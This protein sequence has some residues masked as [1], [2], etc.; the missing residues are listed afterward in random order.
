MRKFYKRA[1]VI[2]LII[3]FIAIP[4]IGKI[5]IDREIKLNVGINEDNELKGD[6]TFVS[7]RTDKREEIQS[8]INE[9]EELYPNVKVNLELIGDAETILQR[10][11]SVGELP[12][13][14][15]VPS[16]IYKNEYSN[17]FLPIDDL[18]FNDNNIYNY[19]MGTGNDSKLYC[20][21][22]SVNWQGV[23][24]NKD[25]FED[26]NIEKL[27]ST[28]EE[29]F[30]ICEKLNDYGVTPIAINYRQ[31]WTM[32][33]CA[34]VI[35]HLFDNNLCKNAAAGNKT[36]LDSESG[37]YKSLNLVREI[38]NR[39]YCEEDLLNYDWQQ[40]K[41]DMST[42]KI[43]MTI[44][45]SDFMYQLED[46]GMDPNSIG[47]F[48][49]PESI[50]VKIYGDY[51][52][53]VSKKTENPQVAKEFLK[54]I[55]EDNRYSNAVNIMSPLKGEDTYSNDFIE[56]NEYDIPIEIYSDYVRNQSVED[57]K[58]EETYLQ[59]KKKNGLDSSFVQKYIIEDNIEDLIKDTN[60][61]WQE[62]ME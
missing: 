33:L 43:A 38:V 23:I 1:V 21:N 35:P 10:K 14:T 18:G 7:N 36:I 8:L 54:Y 52:F 16:T 42:G 17:Y 59:V 56:L 49:I 6:I 22:S 55:F 9:F 57:A 30:E 39:G 40:F 45:S 50:I 48:P 51:K 24:Y 58:L 60:R 3:L 61:K 47:M 19:D 4:I 29:L 25:I 5:F 28:I 37:M 53:A 46:M 26:A 15:L 41:N 62:S 32:N 11:A 2:P 27:P 13:V 12:D 20:L 31:T 34:D 44:W